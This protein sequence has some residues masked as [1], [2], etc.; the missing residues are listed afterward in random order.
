MKTLHWLCLIIFT[1]ASPLHAQTVPDGSKAHPLRV[2]LIPADGGTETGT[3]ADFEPV[4][5]AVTA[6]SGLNFDIKV[7]QS[8]GAVVEAMCNQL[9]DIAFM[10]PVSYVQAHER[11]CAQLLAVSV[12]KGQ[13]IYYAGL[14][15]PINSP[16][17]SIKDLKGKRVAFG[18]INS[19]SSFTFQMAMI[20]EAGLDPIK[21]LAAIRLTGSHANSIAA[22]VQDQV[23]VAALSFDSYE[24]AVREGAVDPQHYKVVVR[25]MPIPNPPIAMNTALPDSVKTKLKNAFATVHHAPGVT[26]EMIRGYGGKKVDRFDTE[27]PE[28][29]FALP[30]QKLSLISDE[31]KGEIL[32]KATAR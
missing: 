17:A 20:L 7:G 2:I 24:K 3:K 25:S 32:K 31:L 10:G 12:E 8:Y 15:A 29:A 26:P 27:F 13:S 30:A 11:H 23:D 14:F 19:A 28:E 21:D 1:F 6:M 16:I 22:L 5:N 18:D 4:F 9:A